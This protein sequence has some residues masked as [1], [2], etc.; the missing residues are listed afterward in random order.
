MGSYGNQAINFLISTIFGLYIAVVMI[1]FILQMVQADFYNPLSQF[2]V[3]ITHPIL[4]PLRRVIPAIG[5]VDTASIVL[6]V[7]LQLA[8]LALIFA[9]AGH[10]PNVAGLA[11]LSVAELIKLSIYVFMFSM[12]ICAVMSWVQQPGM[13]NPVANL[14]RQMSEPIVAPFRKVIPP[15]GGMDF[16]ILV[17][18]IVLQLALILVVGPIKGFAAALL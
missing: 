1:R 14:T 16:S 13:V 3:K 18:I 5:R 17:A 10:M 6:M 11:V 9:L 2:V 15:V 7:V 8:E 12:I 4:A